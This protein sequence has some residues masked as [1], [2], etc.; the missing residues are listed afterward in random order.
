MDDALVIR[1]PVEDLFDLCNGGVDARVDVLTRHLSDGF[2]HDA[3]RVWVKRRRNTHRRSPGIARYTVV[4]LERCFVEN[5]CRHQQ[6]LTT[7]REQQVAY[8]RLDVERL[9]IYAIV[10]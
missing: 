1:V 6:L 5:C 4:A 7:L 3:E 9:Q 2:K 10:V 8:V